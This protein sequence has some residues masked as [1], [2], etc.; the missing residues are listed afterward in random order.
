MLA[1]AWAQPRTSSSGQRTGGRCRRATTSRRM[2]ATSIRA[3]SRR[4][5]GRA[6]TAPPESSSGES[7]RT[8]RTRPRISCAGTA[9][10]EATGWPSS[11]RRRRRRRRSS[12]G[13]GSSA[14][15][16][17]RC[18]CCTETNRF[19]IACRTRGRGSWSP[20]RRTPR[21]S[22]TWARSCSSSTGRG[23]PPRRPSSWAAIRR[24]TTRRSSTTPPARRG[25][26]RGS[27][28]P[29]ATSWPTRSSCTAT[30]SRTASASTAW[31]NGPGPRGSRRCSAPG[32]SA[33]CSACTGARRG[34]IRRS[35]STS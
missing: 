26:P 4:W 17:S 25:S 5:S 6:S 23:S 14:R 10:S 11:C 20:I 19:V 12:S 18:R 27:C 22:R 1:R 30:R 32:G 29:I 34:S 31:A 35:S 28:T 21:V 33:P 16:C 15:S 3:T 7:S 24:P 13:S 8:S 9:S 2:C